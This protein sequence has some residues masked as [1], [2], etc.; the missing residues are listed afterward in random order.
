MLLFRA[1]AES[2]P[3]DDPD[4][5]AWADRLRACQDSNGTVVA[6]VQ[7][8][9]DWGSNERVSSLKNDPYGDRSGEP[10]EVWWP[11]FSRKVIVLKKRSGEEMTRRVETILGEEQMTFGG[12]VKRMEVEKTEG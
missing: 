2:F 9:S 3:R 8:I 1:D 10:K 6:F 11:F 5:L 12:E 7:W 4:I